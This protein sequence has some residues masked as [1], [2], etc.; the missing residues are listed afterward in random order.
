MLHLDLILQEVLRMPVTISRVIILP[1]QKLSPTAR[2]ERTELYNHLDSSCNEPGLRAEVIGDIAITPEPVFVGDTPPVVLNRFQLDSN[3][4]VLPVVERG[5]VVGVINRST[6]IEEHVIGRHG[7]GFH[8]NH[9]KKIRDL[10]STVDLSLESTTT[11]EDAAR[12]IQASRQ[13]LTRM[14]NIFIISKG[15]YAGIVNVNKLFNAIT[16]INLALAKGANPLTGLPGNESIQREINQRLQTGEGFDIAYIDVDNFKPF[17]DYYGFQRGDLVIKAIG[18]I[19]SSVLRMSGK[20]SSF[21]CGHI[22]G[23][24]FIVIGGPYQLEH[25]STQVITSLEEHLPVF[26]GEEDYAAGCY[27][28]MNRKGELETF[29]LLSVSIGIVNTRLT[30]VSSYAQLASISTDIKK[31][32]KKTPGSSVVINRRVDGAVLG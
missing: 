17:N 23:D 15:E 25:I 32:A 9:S 27:S 24:D 5:R 19:I 28:A 16:E 6:F 18:E 13:N 22:G 10:M 3:L 20:E 29:G 11:I 30:T 4:N 26:H 31:A 7:F 14:D 21:F 1:E 8:L 12:L 2:Q